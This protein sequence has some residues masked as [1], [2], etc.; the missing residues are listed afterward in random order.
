MF[1]LTIYNQTEGSWALTLVVMVLLMILV[2]S[3]ALTVGVVYLCHLLSLWIEQFKRISSVTDSLSVTTTRLG[4][5]TVKRTKTTR[6][7]KD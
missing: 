7:R 5:R 4:T 6:F 2:T 3:T 1:P